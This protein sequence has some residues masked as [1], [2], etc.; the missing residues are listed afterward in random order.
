MQPL[1]I[2]LSRYL[3]PLLWTDKVTFLMKEEETK[4]GKK[5]FVTFVRDD[6]ALS[7]NQY[8]LGRIS[9]IASCKAKL[10]PKGIRKQKDGLTVLEHR[11][12][13]WQY[14]RFIQKIETLYPELCIFVD[15][16]KVAR[17]G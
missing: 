10:V 11:C 2:F 13:G 6:H 16:G 8:V 5:T 7:G 12:W 14:K 1:F 9:G 3:R 4:M 17:V 15:L